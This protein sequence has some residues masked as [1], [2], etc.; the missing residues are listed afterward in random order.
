MT[1]ARLPIQLAVSK[2]QHCLAVRDQVAYYEWEEDLM[3]L[4]RANHP[5]VAWWHG[6]RMTP[7]AFGAYCYVCNSLIVSWS[8]RWPI[9]NKA[10]GEIETHK[11][12]HRAEMVSA[13]T[14]SD[15]K[16]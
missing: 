4:A 14:H 5:T 9:T 8:R 2:P 16:G 13:R 15:R 6:R 3:R 11:M 10:K 7:A 12:F 1:S